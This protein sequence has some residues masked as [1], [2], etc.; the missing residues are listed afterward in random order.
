VR[1]I[2]G[3]FLIGLGGFLLVAAVLATVWAPGAVKKTPIDV[4]STTRLEGTVQK[5][6]TAT[7]EM[8]PNDVKVTSITKSDSD[9]STDD[10]AVFVSTTCVVID[11]GTEVP[12]CV[13]G[14]DP[15][16]ISAGVDV[17]A[18]DRVTGMSLPEFDGLP[19]DA[20]AH[21]GLVNKWPFDAEKKTYSYWDGTAGEAVDAVYDRTEEVAGVEAYVYKV[22]IADAPIEIA[23]GVDGT[24][25]DAKEIFI[26]PRTGSIIRQVDDQQR[27]LADGTQV[28]D[29]K[30]AYTDEQAEQSASDADDSA[31]TLGLL[32]KTVPL[33]GFIGG[34]ICI[35]A[36][37]LLMRGTRRRH[38]A[39]HARTESAKTPVG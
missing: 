23:D 26:E 21:E 7:G 39:E 12:D 15:R 34:A 32:L 10:V 25:D 30:I 8:V 11:D 29:L 1:K 16:L 20:V 4:D 33:I 28:L 22:T 5:I 27:Y 3:P 18:T 35:I 2:L 17:F 14:E 36:G 37:L 13:D 31:R 6:D 19:D 38:E 9:A 24:Y